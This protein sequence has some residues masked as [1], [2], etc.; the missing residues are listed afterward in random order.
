VVVYGM[1]SEESGHG[2]NSNK[3]AWAFWLEVPL[4]CKRRQVDEAVHVRRRRYMYTLSP[5]PVRQKANIFQKVHVFGD[6]MWV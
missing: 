3:R 6:R 2:A 4:A 1:A 5:I